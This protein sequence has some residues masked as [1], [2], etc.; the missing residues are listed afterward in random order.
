MRLLL[1]AVISLCAIASAKACDQYTAIDSEQAK[2]LMF[3]L[4]DPGASSVDRLFAFQTLKCSDMPVLRDQAMRVGLQNSQ[5]DAVRGQIMMDTLMAKPNLK[6]ALIASPDLSQEGKEFIKRVNGALYY[7]NN[8]SDPRAGCI[9][10]ASPN[11]CHPGASM[12]FRGIVVTYQNTNE[13][14]E[15]RLTEDNALVGNVRPHDRGAPVPAKLILF[16]QE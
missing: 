3:T 15:F 2:Q 16:D 11:D 12:F 7:K 8:F 10:F 14:G 9:S 6:V 13:I 4:A 5:D 1:V